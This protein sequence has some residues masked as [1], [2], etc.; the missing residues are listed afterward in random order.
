MLLERIQILQEVSRFLEKCGDICI[1]AGSDSLGDW[2]WS[3]ADRA[4]NRIW[5]LLMY[6]S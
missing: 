3:Q 4:D 1:L 2:F 6:C 5:E